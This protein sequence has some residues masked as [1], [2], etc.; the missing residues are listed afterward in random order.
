[1]KIRKCDGTIIDA[2]DDYVL[3][4]GERLVG[5]SFMFMDHALDDTQ[6]AVM[7]DQQISDAQKASDECVA[8]F[9]EAMGEIRERNTAYFDACREAL[10]APPA[11]DQEDPP[12][13]IS[14]PTDDDIAAGRERV[15]AA[16][17]EHDEW[18]RNAWR[19]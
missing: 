15:A 18:L 3:A 2:P 10:H 6:R 4:D 13:S 7:R 1:M 17:A 14:M 11:S 19:G 9:H 5:H 8:A 12:P 16:R